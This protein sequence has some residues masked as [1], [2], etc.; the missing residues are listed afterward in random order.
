MTAYFLGCVALGMV[1][2]FLVGASASPVVGVVLPLLF[3]LLGSAGG[4]LALTFD[5]GTAEARRR[6]RLLGLSA[7]AFALPFLVGVFPGIAVRTGAPLSAVIRGSPEAPVIDPTAI[8]RTGPAATLSPADAAG[9]YLFSR[10]AALAGVPADGIARLLEGALAQRL[11]RLGRFEAE[12]A[13]IVETAMAADAAIGA[14]MNENDASSLVSLKLGSERFLAAI[15]AAPD[16][17]SSL[18]AATDFRA[19]LLVAADDYTIGPLF[20]GDGALA[21]LARDLLQRI[22]ASAG[23]LDGSGFEELVG[24]T[25]GAAG[26]ITAGISLGRGL[27]SVD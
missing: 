6:F 25:A 24:R 14:L 22:P 18:A 20:V 17:A 27:A 11:D 4:V 13:K 8:L 15:R 10:Q 26:G 23:T 2:G 12:R 5:P 19:A 21:P 1:A 3:S 7:L 16:L 9:L